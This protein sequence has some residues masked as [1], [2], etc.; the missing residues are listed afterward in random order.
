MNEKTQTYS[1]RI[2]AVVVEDC[3]HFK[4]LS[5]NSRVGQSEIDEEILAYN[6]L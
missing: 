6:N 2:R 5:S 4:L 3:F 1:G